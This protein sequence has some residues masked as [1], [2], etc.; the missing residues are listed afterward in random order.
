MNFTLIWHLAIRYLRGKRSGNA[1]PILSRIS[2]VAIAVGSGAL[3]I[4]FSVFNGFESLVKDLYK[5]FYPDIKIT[6]AKGKFFSVD[7][8]MLYKLGHVPDVAATS[9]VIEDN[10]L[11]NSGD[12]QIVGTIKGIDKNYFKVNDLKPYIVEGDDSLS[13]TY[14]GAIMGTHIADLMGADVKNVFSSVMFYYPNTKLTNPALDPEAAFQSLKLKPEGI[15]KVQDEF[16][17]KY[18][19][20]SLPLVQNL[21]NES[22]K[23]SS[24]EIRLQN[25]ITPENVKRQLQKILGPSFKVETRFQQ[26]KTLYMVMR[27]EKWAVYAILLLVLLIASF[28]MVGALSL[29]ILEKQKDMAILRAMGAMPS[30]IRQI[31]LIE[32]VLW[33]LTGGLGGLLLGTLLCVGQQQFGWIKIGGSFIIDAYP[34]QLQWP[35]FVLVIITIIL[36]GVLAAWYPA[37]RAAKTEIPSLKTT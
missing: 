21:F 2:M 25:G 31:F 8:S 30:S 33:A 19:L 10:V 6:A 34:I 12:Q 35:D 15:F 26:N 28:N 17:S 4:L 13:S 20:A 3:I 22:G 5:A 1:V 7:S 29:L 14:P 36:V 27:T 18:V 24:I 37:W 9:T 16:D 11:A 32:G 23:I